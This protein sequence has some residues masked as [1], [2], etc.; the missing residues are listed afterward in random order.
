MKSDTALEPHVCFPNMAA[1]SLQEIVHHGP[2]P[3]SA[4]DVL[5]SIS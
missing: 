3:A 4:L 1:A 2:H 5:L